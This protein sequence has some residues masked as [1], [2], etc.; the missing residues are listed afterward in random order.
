MKKLARL[1]CVLLSVSIIVGTLAAC[2]NDDKWDNE[3]DVFTMS[4][5]ELDNVFSPFF[6]TS[7][8]DA[9][10]WG[11]TQI[12]MLTT[13]A[14]GGVY[15]GEDEPTV[16]ANYNQTIMING[17]AVPEDQVETE[18]GKLTEADKKNGDKYY[19]K[20]EFLVKNGIK[21]ST[22]AD[23]TI[24][25]VI[26]NTYVYLDPMYTG[27]ATMYS[28]DIKGLNPY[29]AQEANISEEQMANRE[30]TYAVRAQR[31]Q[32]A[33]MSFFDN[34]SELDRQTYRNGIS[35]DQKNEILNDVILARQ[36]FWQELLDDWN[37][38]IS[39]CADTNE[40]KFT[41]N[42]VWK[43][44]LIMYGI[45]GVDY[46][47][48]GTI[49]VFE[50]YDQ[51]VIDGQ[52]N[53]GDLKIRYKDYEDWYHDKENLLKI[54]YNSKVGV[55][56]LDDQGSPIEADNQKPRVDLELDN[57]LKAVGNTLSDEALRTAIVDNEDNLLANMSSIVTAYATASKMMTYWVADEKEKAF[58][59]KE[60]SDEVPK[61][62][63][64]ITVRKLTAGD[65]FVGKNI[66]TQI[67]EDQYVLCIEINGV[68]PKAIWNF[69]IT[70][71]PMH[72]YSNPAEHGLQSKYAGEG[73]T[74]FNYPGIDGYDPEKDINMGFKNFSQGYMNEVIQAV[75][76]KPVGAGVYMASNAQGREDGKVS[77]NEFNINNI[78]YY[79]RNPYFET[80]GKEMA[81]ARIKYV[82]YKVITS[83]AILDSLFGEE[84]HY[85]MPN[86]KNEIIDQ[87]NGKK[88]TFASYQPKTNGYGYIGINASLVKDL[89]VRRA[90]MIA[91]DTTFIKSY[92][93]DTCEIITRS[94][95][96]NSWAYPHGTSDYYQ[97]STLPENAGAAAREE[98]AKARIEAEL[99]LSTS[100][101]QKDKNGKLRIYDKDKNKWTPL[102]YT[103][104][105]AGA[106]VDH[107]A[108]MTFH[109]AMNILNDLGFQITVLPDAMA[110][111]K[112]AA[113]TL[114]VWA[115]AWGSTIDPDMFQVYHK[116]SKATSVNN[117]GYKYLLD[118][119]SQHV[120]EERR[121]LDELAIEIDNGRSSL[122]ENI[123]KQYYARAL[124]L[125][126]ELAVEYP[127]YQRRDL[128]VINKKVI[129]INSINDDPTSYTGVLSRMW[130]VS[131][132]GN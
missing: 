71:A 8:Y 51:E 119:N 54:V 41:E 10:I 7:S 93:G 66:N 29:R 14:N 39:Y 87:V 67:T 111:S 37:A 40:H 94:M 2:G 47:T 113:G 4:T 18:T 95:S 35:A 80:T 78:I 19:T 82:Q 17:E 115:A 120:T 77:G 58:A 86:A 48:D 116:D 45:I 59:E 109:N 102:K 43:Y 128:Y 53:A 117:W 101:I 70:V 31:R 90:M 81:N 127:T 126:M 21:D 74:E 22:G 99:S 91:M 62:I 88:G 1:I 23:L 79:V 124:D 16:A 33:V 104:T 60:D 108:Y 65:T 68:D 131:F 114:E 6:S 57:D 9:D 64:G 12:S 49:Q 52:Y 106:E 44:F 3:K 15:C 96:T 69:G 112:L 118:S 50:S 107:P 20:Y 84:I 122:S 24:K 73:Y 92:Y 130:E 34:E 27:S 105:I 125:V 25:D 32:L 36:Y 76:K 85:G 42:D 123:R 46:E 129:D 72:Y 56:P 100:Q 103:F 98:D 83:T 28:T 30:Q 89:H 38:A 97:Y 26:F 132:V 61:T 63:S 110:L 11:L 5:G 55:L 75:N 121:I 13:D